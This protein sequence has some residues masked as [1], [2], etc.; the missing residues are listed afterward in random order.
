MDR[1]QIIIL[2]TLV[3]V[4]IG[5]LPVSRK[6]RS[7]SP[8][9]GGTPAEFFHFLGS[10]AYVGVLPAGLLGTLFVGFLRLGLPLAL[11]YLGIAVA[12]LFI[13]AFFE[14]NARKGIT[15][16]DRGWTAEDARSSGL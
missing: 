6:S 12:C 9:Y 15:V 1:T 7:K 4:A 16:E 2:I 8:I 11:T 5:A 3:I 13:Y 14:R 10:A